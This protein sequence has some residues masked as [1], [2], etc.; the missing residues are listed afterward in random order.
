MIET[1]SLLLIPAKQ[2]HLIALSKSKFELGKLLNLRIAVCWPQFAEAYQPDKEI[3]EDKNEYSWGTLFFILKN[4]S[5]LIGS[6]GF[7]GGPDQFGNVEIGYEIATEYENLGY[8]TEA[9]FAMRNFAFDKKEVHTIIAH[10]LSLENAS[11]AVLK[12]IG[13]KFNSEIPDPEL[14]KIWK[15]ILNKNS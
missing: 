1:K 12:K 15:W 2:S 3:Q 5:C 13:M 11:N 14:G 6:G 8:A 9:V 10:T 4:E 7:K